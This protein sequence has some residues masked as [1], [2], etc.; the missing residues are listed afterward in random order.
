MR[1]T[2]V[3]HQ[4]GHRKTGGAFGEKPEGSRWLPFASSGSLRHR[5]NEDIAVDQRLEQYPKLWCG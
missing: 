3:G 2:T 1:E 5:F 4:K